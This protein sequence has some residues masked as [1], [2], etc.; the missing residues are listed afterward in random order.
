MKIIRYIFGFVGF[1]VLWILVTGVVVLAIHAIIPMAGGKVV[2]VDWAAIPG[3]IVGV[4]AGY[5]V[6]QRISGDRPTKGAK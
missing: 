6:Y 3:S 5:P 1:V 4:M 2:G